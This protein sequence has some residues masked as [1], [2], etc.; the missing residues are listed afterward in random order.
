MIPVTL[1]SGADSLLQRA[2][3]RDCAQTEDEEKKDAEAF[4]AAFKKFDFSLED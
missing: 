2:H 3:W 1:R 4:K